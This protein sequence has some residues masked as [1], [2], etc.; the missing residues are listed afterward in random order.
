MG[1]QMPALWGAR[2]GPCTPTPPGPP[3]A[4]FMIPEAHCN[5]NSD[6]PARSHKHYLTKIV[7]LK[8]EKV[9]DKT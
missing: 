1:H 4:R 2:H 8:G 7:R 9:R 3:P 6:N 5:N